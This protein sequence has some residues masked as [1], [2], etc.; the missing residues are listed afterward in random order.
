[1][2]RSSNSARDAQRGDIAE[3]DQQV[4]RRRRR[5]LAD[6]GVDLQDGAVGRRPDA[7]ALQ[8]RLGQRQLGA[9]G[10][11]RRLQPGR[12]RRVVGHAPCAGR[13]RACSS[14]SPALATASRA[15]STS[16]AV[17]VPLRLSFERAVELLAG[18]RQLPLGIGEVVL[19]G[20]AV[21]GRLGHALVVAVALAHRHLGARG[22]HAGDQVLVGEAHQQVAGDHLVVDADQ[23]LG[24]AARHL[25]GRCGSRRP[26]APRAPARRR[27]TP[28]WAPPWLRGLGGLGLGRVPAGLWL[29]VWGT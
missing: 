2:S 7:R 12:R 8:R 14:C 27:P 13:V 29:K 10:G 16:A 18:E 19:G 1:M 22:M 3:H 5:R 23:H 25:G 24:D 4:L 26:A 6:P 17:A 20:A 15:L 21:L 9:R 11:Q 28:S